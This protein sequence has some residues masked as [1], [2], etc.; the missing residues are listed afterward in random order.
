MKGF[1]A[2]VALGCLAMALGCGI[3]SVSTVATGGRPAY[4]PLLASKEVSWNEGR[5]RRDPE[6]AIGWAQLSAAYLK[7]ARQKDDNAVAL[8]AEEAARQSLTLRRK[9]NAGAA[10]LLAKSLLEQHRFHDALEATELASQIEASNLSARELHSEVLVELGRYD[11]AK[12][13]F[14]KYELENV[15]LSGLALEARLLET[16][17]APDKA[18]SVL[19][20]AVMEADRNFDLPREAVA[21]F[22]QKYGGLLWN[23][24]DAA[25]ARHELET[26][27]D[28]YADDFKSMS[29]LARV[30]AATGNL[31]AARAWGEKSVA[32]L[33]TVEAAAL[34]ED[35]APASEKG[36]YQAL[37]DEAAHPDLYGFL[38]DPS[39]APMKSAPHT[40][41]RLYAVYCADHR[42]N[43][44]DALTAAKKDLASRQDIYAFDT[45]AWVLHQMG[46]DGEAAGFM[47]KALARGTKDAKLL[48]HAVLIHGALGDRALAAAE[49]QGAKRIN[50]FVTVPGEASHA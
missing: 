5:V 19:Q 11:E 12:A 14:K 3:P 38:K 10:V 25:G 7:L 33:P 13:E 17:G 50:P 23:R 28:L 44:P 1:Y 4:D 36:K 24:G 2:L 45:M 34:L 15:G 18:Q 35:L 49:L 8:R 9:K 46:R 27:I 26:A 21:W 22:H 16:D 39:A 40:H 6:G 30:Q 41:D 20:R 43:L 48:S 37:V 42:K 31:E 32:I 47:Q 29:L